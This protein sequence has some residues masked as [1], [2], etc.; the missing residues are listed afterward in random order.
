MIFLIFVLP[1]LLAGIYLWMLRGRKNAPG[2]SQLQGYFYAHR[3]LHGASIPENSLAA[4]A[5]AADRGYGSELDV[6][7]LSDGEL[8]VIHDHDLFRVTGKTGTIEQCT[9]GDL[10]QLKLCG[11]QQCVPTFSQVLALYN[12]RAPLVIELKATGNNQQALVDK[13]MEQLAD[14]PGAYCVESFD[15]RC[16]RYLKKRY[17]QVIRGQ[18]SDNFIHYQGNVPLIIRLV[19][20]GLLVNCMGRPDFIAYRFAQRHRLGVYLTRKLWGVQGFA[21]TLTTPEEHE[22][23]RK[24]QWAVIF[25]GYTP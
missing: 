8:A 17:P 18:L 13:V 3:G 14:Y 1:L 2:L 20:T 10:E 9:T 24:E 5:A 25:E 6:H 22:A 4:F 19:M 15:P 23:A 7:L 16:L 21:W 12:A 11:T